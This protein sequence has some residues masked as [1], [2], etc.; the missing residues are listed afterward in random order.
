MFYV[1]MNFLSL[2]AMILVMLLKSL[3]SKGIYLRTTYNIPTR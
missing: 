3:F 2:D 1:L